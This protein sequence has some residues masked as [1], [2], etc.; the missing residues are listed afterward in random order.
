MNTHTTQTFENVRHRIK[1][2]TDIWE[3]ES[4]I[5]LWLTSPLNSWIYPVVTAS[6]TE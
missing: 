4:I 5:N 3:L 6:A 2:D 1:V